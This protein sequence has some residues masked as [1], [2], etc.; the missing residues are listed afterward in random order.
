MAKALIAAGAQ[1]GP[2]GEQGASGAAGAGGADEFLLED[3]SLAGANQIVLDRAPD[4]AIRQGRVAIGV[5]LT[6]CEI[7]EVTTISTATLTL[8]SRLWHAHDADERIVYFGET[9][10]P[11]TWWGAQGN[12]S[13]LDSLFNLQC[14]LVAVSQAGTTPITLDGQSKAY[15]VSGPHVMPQNIGIE[16][17]TIQAKSDYGPADGPDNPVYETNAMSILFQGVDKFTYDQSDNL[18]TTVDA[19]GNASADGNLSVNSRIMFIDSG[20]GL[21]LPTGIVP[22]RLYAITE[23]P[24]SSTF[25]VGLK[26]GGSTI[27]FDSDGAGFMGAQAHDNAKLY[28]RRLNISGSNVGQFVFTANATTNLMTC[29]ASHGLVEGDVVR[30]NLPSAGSGLLPTGIEGGV[31]TYY[32]IADGLTATA[33]KVSEAEGGS[34]VDITAA[35]DGGFVVNA[36]AAVNGAIWGLQQPAFLENI[37]IDNCKGFGVRV[38]TQQSHWPNVMLINNGTSMELGEEDGGTFGEFLYIN[39]FNS[40]QADTRDM[41]VRQGTAVHIQNV[42]IEEAERVFNFVHF[43]VEAEMELFWVRHCWFSTAGGTTAPGRIMFRF[44]CGTVER[45]DYLIEG[46]RGTF[47]TSAGLLFIQDKDRG[48]ELDMLT[49]MGGEGIARFESWSTHTGTSATDNYPYTWNGVDGAAVIWGTQ[50]GT[51]PH[52]ITRAGALKTADIERWQSWTRFGAPTNATLVIATGVFTLNSHGLTEGQKI[53]LAQGTTVDPVAPEH[54]ITGGQVCYV[55]NPDTNTFQVSKTPT[56]DVVLF[57]GSSPT[58]GW[59]VR[60]LSTTYP[61]RVNKE[62]RLIRNRTSAIADADLNASDFDMHLDS[63]AGASE[64]RAKW[65]DAGGTV[66]HQAITWLRGSGTHDWGS[67]ANGAMDSTTVTVTGAAVGDFAVASMS[68]APPAGV[69]YHAQVTAANTVTVSRINHSGSAHDP[70]SGTLRAAVL[71]AS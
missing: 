58:T 40:E 12:D 30:F 71:G 54:W 20:N 33:F 16:N 63:T 64:L 66:N 25:K 67:L 39:T 42:H 5:G 50:N 26:A 52:Q 48:I 2:Q 10:V 65:K 36:R 43:D 35:N 32:V 51:L 31:N 18:F 59:Q 34:A 14:A 38:L 53:H 62:A 7:R 13:S 8:S 4:F 27:A 68:V 9:R 56:S 69:V 70:T 1:P 44:D 37:R 17:I 22:G 11:V 15:Y 23:E 46:V 41:R 3:A 49:D 60:Y 21:T 28:A 61:L 29:S 19:Q 57:E 45:T 6:T 24:T 55:R 47:P